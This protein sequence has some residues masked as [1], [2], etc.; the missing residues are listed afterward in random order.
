MNNQN[1]NW[2]LSVARIRR[3][4]IMSLCKK[5]LNFLVI[6]KLILLF[7]LSSTICFYPENFLHAQILPFRHYTT[8]DGLPQSQITSI[9]QDQQGYL[10]LGTRGGICRYNGHEF[11]NFP[12]A[13]RDIRCVFE[14]HLARI[15][16]GTNGGGLYCLTDSIH[17]TERDAPGLNYVFNIVQDQQ[18]NYWLATNGGGLCRM[19]GQ[20][21]KF[22]FAN[23]MTEHGM[24]SDYLRTLMISRDGSIFCG[25]P[26][27]ISRVTF[28]KPDSIAVTN[29]TQNDGLVGKDVLTIIQG[30]NGRIW[31]GTNSALCFFEP[32][33]NAF[34]QF[35][36]LSKSMSIPVRTLIETHSGIIWVGSF[37]EG[38]FRLSRNT[39]Q[40]NYQY[41]QITTQNG[42][43]SNNISFAFED[44][45]S[46]L[47]L[48]CWGT[49]VSKLIK[50]GFINY[51]S[52]NGLAGNNIF[53]IHQDKNGD[54]WFGNHGNGISILTPNG[55]RYLNS[56]NGLVSDKI[57]DILTDRQGITWIATSDGVSQYNASQNRFEHL[58]QENGLSSS[59]VITLCEDRFGRIWM[60][61]ARTGIIVLDKSS[62]KRH[63]TSFTI[64]NG[65]SNNTI[66]TLFEASD[67]TIWCGTETGLCKIK[68]T[69]SLAD[70]SWEILPFLSRTSIWSFYEDRNKN[71]WIG[72]NNF[73][74]ARVSPD[75]EITYYTEEDGLCDNTIYLIQPDQD[76]II[77]IGTNDGIDRLYFDG[78]VLVRNKHYGL[79]VGLANLETNMNS[80]LLDKSGKFWFGTVS[81]VSGFDPKTD[82]V[83]I[84]PPLV[85]IENIIAGDYKFLSPQTCRLNYKNNHVTFNYRGLSFRNEAQVLYQYKL[86]GVDN[87]WQPTTS[88]TQVQ[89]TNLSPGEY[90]F[91]VKAA[92]SDEIWS[93]YAAKATVII[94]PPWF[95]TWWFHALLALS[96]ILVIFGI[97][98]WRIHDIKST[99]RQLEKKVRERTLKLENTLKRQHEL[100][101]QLFQS[102]KMATLGQLSAS[103]THEINNPIAYVINNMF[104]IKKNMM[105][106]FHFF[107]A[108]NNFLTK[109]PNP[110]KFQQ[111]IDE[112]KTLKKEE[113]LENKITVILDAIEKNN[114]GLG[115]VQTIIES[116]KTFTRIDR[117]AFE[118]EDIH[119]CIESALEI[120]QPQYRDKIEIIRKYGNLSPTI[121]LPDQLSQVFINLLNNAIQSIERQ[122]RIEI[123]TKTIQK[124][125]VIEIEDNGH[126]I[127][128]KILEKI[129]DPFFTTKATGEGM[130]L[131]LGIC[132]GIIEKHHG[133]IEVTSKVG[134]G[135]L[136]KITLPVTNSEEA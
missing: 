106:V 11:I 52:Q 79:P 70:C 101:F 90:I 56:Q 26:L 89:Y 107:D 49:G 54:L 7:I 3:Y 111:F 109:I 136:F 61:T 46:N 28:F 41:Q 82:F 108:T 69:G 21:G 68:I 18:D 6:G 5:N 114:I 72:T 94:L 8:A 98:R 104:I 23:F 33:L 78:P 97:H 40:Q 123:R 127:P 113:K 81:G 34:K 22:L 10:W 85:H 73:G 71:M 87:D 16:V 29:Y 105:K 35:P 88:L 76:D 96:T 117:S 48:G 58:T 51:S 110:I 119:Q 80:C 93:S 37:N 44:R 60:G 124:Q 47:W 14:D 99:N 128:P 50:G 121:C 42:L 74:L 57:W 86:E 4:Y 64:E 9:L 30:R 59:N 62:G 13:N 129:F 39:A 112:I 135:S 15:W 116:L 20:N 17:L 103:I 27:G 31:C 95:G 45:E 122:G 36:L 91:Q 134:Q 131:G 65:L 100:E 132:Q 12:I 32:K 115:R 63:F 2:Q 102:T 55:F 67:S 84:I 130:G 133:K 19:T 43:P 53:A 126:G 83:N 1:N 38:L 25:S 118:L 75:N 24:I 120:L 66:Y 125:L 77:W 92:N